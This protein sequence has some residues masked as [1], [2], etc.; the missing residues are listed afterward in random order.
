MS[1]HELN[2][3]RSYGTRGH[4]ELW[5]VWLDQVLTTHPSPTLTLHD[6]DGRLTSCNLGGVSLKIHT[7]WAHFWPGDLDSYLRTREVDADL[8]SFLFS[9]GTADDIGRC[10][11][12]V[13]CRTCEWIKND[14][15]LTCFLF[16][17]CNRFWESSSFTSVWYLRVK[18]DPSG[19]SFCRLVA[20]VMMLDIFVVHYSVRPDINNHTGWLGVKHQ[21]TY[22]SVSYLRNKS[23][24]FWHVSFLLA[25]TEVE[26]L[27]HSLVCHTC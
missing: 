22:Y 8:S 24:P 14:P 13:V 27:R 12:L 5:Q 6:I 19:I 15:F 17:G 7:R 26:I 20:S 25:A 18:R 1:G 9:R 4:P 2:F 10:G 16:A 21:L 23:D 11:R 3:C